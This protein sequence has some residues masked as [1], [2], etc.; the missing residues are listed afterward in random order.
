MRYPLFPFIKRING[1]LLA[2]LV[3]S[4]TIL[5][6]CDEGNDP[7][8][9]PEYIVPGPVVTVNSYPLEVG[10]R[11]VY[12]MRTVVTGAVSSDDSYMVD[13]SVKLDTTIDGVPVK[14]VRATETV[15]T[16]VGNDRLGFRYFSQ[17]SFG[18]EMLAYS[19]SNTQVFFKDEQVSRIDDFSFVSGT[20]AATD[21]VVIR[22][23]P[24]RYMRLPSVDGDIW[25]SNEFIAESGFK[26]RWGGYYTVTTDAGT[27]DCMKLE[28]FGD[29][30]NDSIPQTTGGLFL[31]QYI[32]PEFGLIKEVDMR[33][34]TIIGGQSALLVRETNLVSKSF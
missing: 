27:F 29:S 26:R 17:T 25:G 33:D 24:L 11:W 14:K 22:D 6:S 3:L 34:L 16:V 21:S 31:E 30:D 1:R 10:N 23:V 4:V 5:S 13:F 32:S 12:S 7:E 18:L 28:L 9:Q 19:G 8:P 15:G 20:L 2:L